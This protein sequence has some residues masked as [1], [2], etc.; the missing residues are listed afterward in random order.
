KPAGKKRCGYSKRIFISL[1]AKTNQATEEIEGHT[2]AKRKAPLS[3]RCVNGGFLFQHIGAEP[4]A[5]QHQDLAKREVID[6]MDCR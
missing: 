4:A 6:P 2:R 1:G 3:Q 5:N